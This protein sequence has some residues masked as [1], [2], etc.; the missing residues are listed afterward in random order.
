M[1]CGAGKPSKYIK[2]CTSP[3]PV[4]RDAAIEALTAEAF[5]VRCLVEHFT[6]PSEFKPPHEVNLAQER[7]IPLLREA[8][9]TKSVKNCLEK[10]RA[11]C[12][13]VDI[14]VLFLSTY[15]SLARETWGLDELRKRADSEKALAYSQAYT[16][17]HGIIRATESEVY[18][19][20]QSLINSIVTERCSTEIDEI[21]D[22][23]QRVCRLYVAC[24]MMKSKYFDPLCAY[25]ECKTLGTKVSH[26]PIKD[27]FRVLEKLVLRPK[28]GVPWDVVRAQ[29]ICETMDQVLQ[30]LK[31]IKTFPSIKFVRIND[32]FTSPK[33]GWADVA[34]Y[35]SFDDVDCHS[36]VAEIQIVH[37]KMMLVR[38]NM[39]AHNV[40]HGGRFAAELLRLWEKEDSAAAPW[41]VAS[42]TSVAE[43]E[44]SFRV[45]ELLK[46]V[47]EDKIEVQKH[48]GNVSSCSKVPRQLQV[49]MIGKDFQEQ[50][51]KRFDVL[52]RDGNGILTAEELL[53]I[54]IEI[55]AE[56]GKAVTHEHCSRLLTIFDTDCD[57]VLSR[58]EFL[59]FVQFLH[60]MQALDESEG[61]PWRQS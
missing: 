27:A 47:K 4:L 51:N 6:L 2:E 45:D 8:F 1:G 33:N 57:G 3:E 42:A 21:E 46:T 20:L 10:Q 54:T 38:E 40:Y 48:Y 32:R 22:I 36:V 28:G 23:G 13:V 15:V 56:C 41:S 52:D 44:M 60:L 43:L 11:I 59:E 24:N 31:V 16:A 58:A 25:I 26:G 53:P 19:K 37:N 17:I 50:C 5:A 55:A 35:V 61:A 7:I 12:L 18:G 49:R 9:K 14:S 29:V 39:K 34:V 30:V